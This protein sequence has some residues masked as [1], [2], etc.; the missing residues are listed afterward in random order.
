MKGDTMNTKASPGT[1]RRQKLG[2]IG[3][4]IF[5]NPARRNAVSRDMVRQVPEVLADFESD[6]DIR[7]VV[8]SGAGDKSFISGADIS[9]FEK[10][11][12]NAQVAKESSAASMAMFEGLR[13]FSKPTVAKVRGY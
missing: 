5:D 10:T 6:P 12:A 3:H 1:I 2:G 13:E 7:V 8:V 9:E 11:R 4:L